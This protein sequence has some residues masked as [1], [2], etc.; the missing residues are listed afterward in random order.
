MVWLGSWITR[1]MIIVITTIA[2][3]SLA[4]NPDVTAVMFSMPVKKP[5]NFP[6]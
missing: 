1:Q 2:Q 6:D 3:A 4:V 5:R